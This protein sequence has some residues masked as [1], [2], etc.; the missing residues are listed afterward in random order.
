MTG[1]SDSVTLLHFD[2][3][4]HPAIKGGCAIPPLYKPGIAEEKFYESPEDLEPEE[5]SLITKGKSLKKRGRG[6]PRPARYRYQGREIDNIWGGGELRPSFA[7]QL[8]PELRLV[9]GFWRQPDLPTLQKAALCGCKDSGEFLELNRKLLTEP[10]FTG[11]DAIRHCILHGLPMSAAVEMKES[12]NCRSCGVRTKT[13]PCVNCWRGM[14]DDPTLELD[15]KDTQPVITD[16]DIRKTCKPTKAQPGSD[17]KIAVLRMRAEKGLP[18]W[19]PDDP[20]VR[21]HDGGRWWLHD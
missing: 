8:R 10:E 6:R 14:D 4:V 1:A 9:I 12:I 13:L 3:P 5:I 15:A 11:V 18:L 2:H 7:R 19:H 16:E 20:V 17:A 21:L